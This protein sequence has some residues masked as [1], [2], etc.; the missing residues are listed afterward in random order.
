[1][2]LF[3]AAAALAANHSLDLDGPVP[4][5]THTLA[6]PNTAIVAVETWSGDADVVVEVRGEHGWEAVASPD[7]TGW[8]RVRR[9]ERPLRLRMEVREPV[10][11]AVHDVALVEASEE[12]LESGVLL[13]HLVSAV[14]LPVPA[15]VAQQPA[16]LWA[17]PWEEAACLPVS[18]GWLPEQTWLVG[19]GVV[20][21]VGADRVT[22]LR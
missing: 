5:G 12:D 22:A 17:C 8:I 7:G 10:R 1:M 6:L 3:L 15:V 4:A 19:S 9:G 2:M 16:D 18:G 14:Q 13:P 21:A 20:R 11:V